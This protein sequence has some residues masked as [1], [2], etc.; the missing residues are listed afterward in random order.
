MVERAHGGATQHVGRMP[1]SDAAAG[2]RTAAVQRLLKE[3]EAC[4]AAE[5]YERAARLRDRIR[6][7]RAE[8]TPEATP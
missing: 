2:E 1:P 4:V 8:G 6:E 5:Q 7:M 3:L